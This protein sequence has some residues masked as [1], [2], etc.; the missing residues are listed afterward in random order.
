MTGTPIRRIDGRPTRGDGRLEG[1]IARL[2]MDRVLKAIKPSLL[3]TEILDVGCGSHPVFLLRAPFG[4]KV[5]IDQL[6][7]AAAVGDA[8]SGPMPGGAV[9]G[10]GAREGGTLRGDN[11]ELL[12]WSLDAAPRL[13]FPDASFSCVTSLAV[14]EHL[15]PDGLPG[16]MAE[17]HRVLKP[18][19]QLL[20][21][22]PHAAADGLLR[23]LARMGLVSKEEIDEHKSLFLH[24]HIRDLLRQAGFPGD[25]IRVG[26][27][28]L[29]LNIL[30]VAEK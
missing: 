2:R 23:L 20:L 8:V 6:A 22:T 9:P 27:F 1:F 19:G 21:T 4:R 29:G 16:L 11:L 7:P 13:P 26:G 10:G 14:I 25:R 5:G 15:E 18:S 30:A 28:L 12:Q 3:G 17:L 24:R